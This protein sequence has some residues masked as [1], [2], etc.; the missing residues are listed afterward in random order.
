MN[1]VSPLI[2]PL[3]YLTLIGY[4]FLGIWFACK[5]EKNVTYKV[6]WSLL[7]LCIPFI[8]STFYLMTYFMEPDL[9]RVIPTLN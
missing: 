3:L 6:M 9:K 1:E 8:G 2:L 7:I 4:I 5:N